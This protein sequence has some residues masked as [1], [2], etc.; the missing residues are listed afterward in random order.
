VWPGVN[1][2]WLQGRQRSAAGVKRT[3]LGS[4]LRRP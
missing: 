1:L 4:G 3:I 2:K